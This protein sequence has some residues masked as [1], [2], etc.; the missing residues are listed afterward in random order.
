MNA[1]PGNQNQN[2]NPRSVSHTNG[3]DKLDDNSRIR[4]QRNKSVFNKVD[5]AQK[6]TFAQLKK[7]IK[8]PNT[9]RNSFNQNYSLAN[10]H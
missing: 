3:V 6:S 8:Q 4:D 2:Q 9:Q 7:N 1:P 10:L 5:N